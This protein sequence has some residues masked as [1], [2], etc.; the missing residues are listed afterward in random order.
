MTFSSM[1]LS[2]TDC[3]YNSC[4]DDAYDDGTIWA[5]TA[6]FQYRLG[7]LPGGANVTILYWF[8]ADFTELGSLAINPGDGQAGPVTS[9]KDD[10]WLAVFS[11]WQYLSA[12]GAGEGPLDLS[13][14]RPDL[15][16]WGL[17]GRLSFADKDSN[18]FQTNVSVGIGGRGV[19]PSRPNDVFG[20]GY[21][22]NDVYSDRFTDNTLGFKGDSQ[23]GEAFYNL[24]ITPAA[25][26]S[27]NC[28][29]LTSSLNNEDDATVLSGRLHLVF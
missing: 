8:D 29:Y 18:P 28:Q 16:G 15:E 10:S 6:M 5:N 14:Q 11:F 9:T 22:Y 3:S 25:K 24:A 12:K 4:I 2:A 7:D 21:F 23:G 26:F 27:L 17:F 20:L 1:L 19:I 13:N